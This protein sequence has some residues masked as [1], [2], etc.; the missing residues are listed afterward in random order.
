MSDAEATALPATGAMPCPAP[1]PALVGLYIHVPFCSR[2]CG[3]CSFNTYA[4]EGTDPR[5]RYRRY[6]EGVRAELDLAATALAGGPALTS[7]YLGGGTPTLLGGEGVTSI[8]DAVRTRL[9]LADDVEVSVE[10]NPDTV[11]PV[12]LGSLAAAGVDRVSFG[13]QSTDAFVLD[14]LDRT[15]S[16]GRALAAVAQARRAGIRSV[17][18]DLIAGT[19]GESDRSWAATIEAAIAAQPD[20]ISVYSLSIE[21]GTKLAAQVRTGSLPPPDPDQ[22]A[23]RYLWTDERLQQAG[24]GW[25]E[26]SNWA[27]GPEHR[28]RHNLGYW[29]NGDW[30]GI[31]PGAHS[32][33]GR[34][35]WWN[36]RNPERWAALLLAGRSPL[37][38]QETLTVEQDR[39]ERLLL[40]VRLVE[41]VDIAAV[42][43][44]AVATIERDGL[45]R[46]VG[47]RLVL[48][49]RGRLMA[50]RVALALC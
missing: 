30:W 32:H 8:L 4:V 18:V 17:S 16:P 25:Y 22:Q 24:F 28:C 23:D 29:R 7:V 20:H 13:V 12:L 36:E 14:L 34:R 5:A 19:P 1:G 48:T 31:G 42:D 39:L 11:D 37:D 10:A 45:A 27:T 40:G 41:G 6:L 46:L 2:R 49:P 35:R 3:Y 26:I 44:A 38:G 21:P 43:P 50:D 47:S 15:H 33:L 9:P